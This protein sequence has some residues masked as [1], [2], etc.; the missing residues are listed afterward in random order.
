MRL[1]TWNVNSLRARLPRVL[2]WIEYAEPDVL[3][4]QETKLA[5]DQV[6]AMDFE[7]LGY[8]IAHHGEGRWNGVAIASRVGVD[9]VTAGFGDLA[10][11]YEGEARLVAARCGRLGIV[12]VYVPNG[13]EVGSETYVRKLEWLDR[14][15]EWIDSRYAPEDHLVVCGDWNVAPEDRDVYSMEEMAGATHITPEERERLA[16]LRQ[17]GLVDAFR[18]VYDEDRLF[19][20]WDYRAG[21]FHK[22]KG[23]R[24]DLVY[25]TEAVADRV[26]WALVDR[27]A[28][29]GQKPSDHAPVVVDVEVE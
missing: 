21:N 25:A 28:R 23:L 13:R 5:D 8:T 12:N 27:N 11:P 10:D 9:D 2:E 3:C 22:H 6:P 26:R 19:T 16:R 14:L 24:I 4:L 17:W 15:R 7:Q 18:R 20:W 29:K 1:A